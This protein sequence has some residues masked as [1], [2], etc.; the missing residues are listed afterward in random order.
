M[1]FLK[2]LTVLLSITLFSNQGYA[3]ETKY[4]CKPKSAAAVRSMVYKFLKLLEKK[5]QSKLP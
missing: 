4:S 2:F 5:N 1:N 3:K